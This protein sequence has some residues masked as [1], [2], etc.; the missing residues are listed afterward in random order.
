MIGNKLIIFSFLLL[1]I[2]FSYAGRDGHGGDYLLCRFE[3]DEASLNGLEDGRYNYFLDYALANIRQTQS[4][5]EYSFPLRQ[6]SDETLDIILSEFIKKPRFLNND[7]VVR[8]FR[9]LLSFKNTL[10][11]V[12]ESAIE[13]PEY[14]QNDENLIDQ[15]PNMISSIENIKI[16]EVLESALSESLETSRVSYN[17]VL[18]NLEKPGDSQ[19]VVGNQRRV[20]DENIEMRFRDYI[21]T[22]AD[23]ICRYSSNGRPYQ[24]VYREEQTMGSGK[25]ERINITYILNRSMI[26]NYLNPQAPK[27]KMNLSWMLFHEYLWNIIDGKA[28]L[29]RFLN[30]FFHSIAFKNEI[31][32]NNVPEISMTEVKKIGDSFTS[33]ASNEEYFGINGVTYLTLK[34][35]FSI[36]FDCPRIY[37]GDSEKCV[38][39]DDLGPD[40]RVFTTA[41]SMPGD[42]EGFDEL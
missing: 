27:G 12:L 10:K 18:E 19:M 28:Q 32:G 25:E 16:P 30:H 31:I 21:S 39:K 13:N 8:Y 15:I 1:S 24:G 40:F 17:W 29:N 41:D 23:T 3:Q 9:F 34:P 20:N 42:S 22:D 37:E 33:R 26:I 2:S 11:S 36:V 4:I 14:V 7:F 6:G 35:V 5:G 38:E